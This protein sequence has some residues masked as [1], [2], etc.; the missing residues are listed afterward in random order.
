MTLA[1]KYCIITVLLLFAEL[2]Y[3]RLAFRY[4]IVDK[5][6]LR[7]SHKKVTILG[8]GVIFPI[9]VWL[10]AMF[11]KVH[12]PWFLAGL[13]L[14][15]IVSFADDIKS[16]PNKVRLVVQFLA[17]ILIAHDLGLL[18]ANMW[19]L[20]AALIISVGIV[21]AYNFMDGINGM[22]GGYS[23]AVLVPL[24]VM[25]YY[26]GQELSLHTVVGIS[27]LIFCYFN[28]RTRAKCFAGDI[29]A[30]SMAFI[31]IFLLG[32]LILLTKDLSYIIFLAVYGV[33]TVLTIIHRIMLHERIGL[34][35]RK[36]MYQIMANEL[37]IPHVVVSSIYAVVQLLI[38]AGLIWLP[39]NHYLYAGAVLLLL[40]V[41]YLVFMLKYYHLHAEYLASIAE[42][43]G[44]K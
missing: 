5:P 31:L 32:R 27:L 16:V 29:G 18:T 23:L 37:K 40:F 4:R 28:F 22:T 21:N 9:A 6:N 11:F 30:M 7:S 14:V 12:D 36:H 26:I 3:F 24:T 19:W 43:G 10:W 44:N 2:L 15:S 38:S 8:G 25:D 35:H 42:N 33:D 39:I 1:I 17:I 41:I 20:I 34:G 13:S